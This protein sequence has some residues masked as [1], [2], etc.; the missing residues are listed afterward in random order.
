M[1]KTKSGSSAAQ[2]R[3]QTRQQRQSSN[4]SNT[5]TRQQNQRGRRTRQQKQRNSNWIW[6]TATLVLVVAIIGVFIY[7][8]HQP[9]PSS[10]ASGS[11][12][13]EVMQNITNI[14]P[15]SLATVGT[16]GVQNPMKAVSGATPLVGSD[17]KPEF[18]YAGAEY[19]PYC[20]AQ[21]WGMIV[22][23]SR[24]GSFSGVSEITSSEDNLSTFSFYGS[25]YS[26]Q[27]ID[28]APV[29]L[30]N[31]QDKA[32]ETP[33][34]AQ[35][36]LIQTYDNPPYVSSSSAGA[37]PFIDIGNKFVSTGAYYSATDISGLSWTDI[38]GQV[39]NTKTQVSKDIL[40]TANY[41]TSAICSATNNQPASVCSVAPIPQIELTLPKVSYN[42]GHGQLALAS[43]TGDIIE[44][45]R[46]I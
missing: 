43:Y 23:L 27:Y 21:R 42:G 40:G 9:A 3:E 39:Q 13:K 22:A 31:N 26:S 33:T 10:T 28:F 4:T 35:Q 17:G 25:H 34:S 16:G 14:D 7:L 18:F 46:S 12:T 32:L 20:A 24:F 36:K 45:K 1:A 29:E 8:S 2:R 5:A 44:T 30:Y 37:I 6:V 41:L 38:S 19:C 15:S 11:S